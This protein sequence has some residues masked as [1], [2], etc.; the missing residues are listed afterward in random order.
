[1]PLTEIKEENDLSHESEATKLETSK[2]L[3]LA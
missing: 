3:V 2:P 1:M